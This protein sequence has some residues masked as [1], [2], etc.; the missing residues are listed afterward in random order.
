MKKLIEE[1]GFCGKYKD[2]I[3][4]YKTDPKILIE[5]IRHYQAE[6]DAVKDARYL[7]Y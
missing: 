5:V 3:I 6:L 2:H 1:E 4:C 7:Q